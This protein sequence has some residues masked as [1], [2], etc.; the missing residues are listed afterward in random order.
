MSCIE[1]LDAEDFAALL[2]VARHAIVGATGGAPA[3]APPDVPPRCLAPGASFVTL[4]RDDTLRG[5]IGSLEMRRALCDDVA[6]N[7]LAAARQD[8]RFPPLAPVELAHTAVEISVLGPAE[9]L[10]YADEAAFYARLRP[11]VDGLIIVHGGRRATFL[12]AV[13]RQ[14]PD[15]RR[16]VAALRRK[17]GID[18]D[19]PL[20]ALHISR[21]VTLKGPSAPLL[22][23]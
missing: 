22:A 20:T 6:V 1:S 2:G 5:C 21:Y 11:G 7:A 23:G 13:W 18:A 12:P 3:P 16:F 9:P 10:I 14:L 15:P 19:L 17:A 8:P 4:T